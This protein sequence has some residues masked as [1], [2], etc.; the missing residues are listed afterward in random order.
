M[1]LESTASFGV[2]IE[3]DGKPMRF[4]HVGSSISPTGPPQL[5]GAGLGILSLLPRNTARAW[6]FLTE[7]DLLTTPLCARGCWA[8]SRRPPSGR[9]LATANG[10]LSLD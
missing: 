10:C 3:L 5:L 7:H 9:P 4:F 8:K 1:R 2:W 6:S